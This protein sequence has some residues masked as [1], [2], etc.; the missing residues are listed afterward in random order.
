MYIWIAGLCTG[1]IGYLMVNNINLC[2]LEL[3]RVNKRGQAFFFVFWVLLFEALY[4]IGSLR[5]M[6]FLLQF[7]SWVLIA[8]IAAIAFLLVIGAWT[9][10]EKG[11]EPEERLRKNIILRGYWS[12]FVHPQQI[13]FWLFWGLLLTDKGIMEAEDADFLILAVA[14]SIGAL[15]VLALY[16]LAGN[17]LIER[18]AV[19]R[20]FLKNLVGVIC[21]ISAAFL[22]ADIIRN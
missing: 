10:L 14:N 11:N 13:P 15:L 8:R 19:N 7:P 3:Q 18:F 6:K 2:L 21:L 5:G 17:Q 22:L 12:V 20:R 9:L 1:F 4:C 16:W